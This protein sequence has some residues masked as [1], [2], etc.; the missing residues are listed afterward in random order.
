MSDIVSSFREAFPGFREWTQ[1]GLRRVSYRTT[2]VSRVHLLQASRSDTADGTLT[3]VL[4]RLTV[5]GPRRAT[6]EIY[7]DDRLAVPR[8]S[9][10]ERAIG[11]FSG[12]LDGTGI[13]EPDHVVLFLG[14]DSFRRVEEAFLSSA[15]ALYYLDLTLKRLPGATG[16]FVL[17]CELTAERRQPNQTLQTTPMTRSE[18]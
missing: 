6:I 16:A 2:Q 8:I 3:G 17:S 12:D 5:D 14:A 11:R 4:Y 13:D 18:I 10:S 1:G 15:Q 9:D 7:G